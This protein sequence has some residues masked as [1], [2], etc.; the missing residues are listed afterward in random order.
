[1][2]KQ[3][4]S[5]IAFII[6]VAIMLST[7]VFAGAVENDDLN[8]E[9]VGTS[10]AWSR[11]IEFDKYWDEETKEYKYRYVVVPEKNTFCDPGAEPYF[12]L[13]DDPDEENDG[14]LHFYN[15]KPASAWA[16][17]W[18]I[19]PTPTGETNKNSDAESGQVLPTGS[20][21]KMTY[22]VR[23][24]STGGGSPSLV[25]FYGYHQGRHSITDNESKTPN[26]VLK[27]GLTASDDWQT[28]TVY[29]TTPDE[30]SVLTKGVAN[31][32]YTGLLC[33]GKKMD[34]DL[35]YIK[36]EKVVPITYDANG[37]TFSDG[38][39]TKTLNEVVGAKF[40]VDSPIYP[41]KGFYGWSLD[42]DGGEVLSKVESAHSGNTLY[43]VWGAPGPHPAD[44]NYDSWS[45]TVEFDQYV[46]VEE[47]NTA[48]ADPDYFRVDDDPNEEGDKYLHYY[49]HS[50]AGSWAANWSITP[51]PTGVTNTNSDAESGQVLPTG[52]TFKMTYRVRIN[53]TGGGSPS[54]VI[55]YGYHQ[56]RHSITDNE[57]KTP[58]EVLKTGL[59]ASDDWQT[60]TVYF[61]TPDEYSVLTKG[62]ANRFYTGLLCGGY[63]MDYDLDYI[64]LEKVTK[65]NLYVKAGSEYVLKETF[66]GAPGET[67]NLPPY[68]SE[69]SYSLYGPTGSASK[70]VYG[71]WYSDEACTAAPILKFGNFDVDLYCSSVTEIPAVN[72]KNQD[73]FVGFD[74]YTQRT[75]GLKNAVVTN[76]AY[77]TG[78]VSLK[79]N[80]SASAP[81]FFELKNDHTLDV[82]S[83]KTYRIDF[84]YKADKNSY[85]DFGLANGFID[86]GIT[87]K[88]SVDLK[89][90]DDWTSASAIIT[91]DGA[92]D[93]SVLAA[94]ISSTVDADVFIDTIIVS[95]ATESVGVEAETTENGEALR[96]MLSYGGETV[97]MA[98]NDYTVTE[99]GVLVKGEEL[100]TALSLENADKSGIF[101]FS[102]TDLTKN[103]SVN[104]ITGT[105]VYSAYLNGFDKNDD[106]K[107]SVRGYV[108]LTDGTVYYS[109]I[110]TA[111]ITDIPAAKDIVPENANLSDYYVYL[112]EGTTLPADADYTVTTYDD[113]FN[114]NSAVEGNLITEDSYVLFSARP[115]F[116]KID[117]PSELKYL[118]HAGTKAELYYGIEAQI[119]SEKISE[120]GSDTVNYLFIT[121]IHYSD[122]AKKHL[123]NQAALMAKMANENDDIDFIV[124]GGDT[125]TGMFETKE[126]YIA[127][128]HTALDPFL[129]STKPVFV[130][131]GN[132]DD[133]SYHLQASSN[134]NY[135]LYEERII[136]DLDWQ[137]YIID[138]Y[139]NKGNIK[140]VQDD[141]AKRANSKYFYY[142]L[143][144]KKTRVIALDALDYEAKYDENGYVLVDTD[145]DGL[146]DGMPIKDANGTNDGLKYYSGCS[147][148]GY[149]ADQIR[150]LAEDA[151]GDL[152]ADYDVI[153][154]SHMG[155]DKTTNAY[156]SKIWFG[157]NIREIIKTF[158]AGGTYTAAL[159]DNWG[160][161]VSVNADFS[162]TN[163][164][165]VVWQFGHQHVE[166]TF[167]ESDVGL[168]QLCTPSAKVYNS[169]TDTYEELANSKI[170]RKDLPWRVYTR[171]LGD[172]TEACF[173]AMSVSSER[174]Y[175]FS[176]GQGNNEKL[177]YAE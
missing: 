81:A 31:R 27:T 175:R 115:D 96:F 105:T 25:I 154:V 143:E 43:A 14:Y 130:L 5:A 148:W 48:T 80:V 159:T 171:K 117:V 87:S 75:E 29:F 160:N 63:K 11:T 90:A 2:T 60:I 37:G 108:K 133:N 15:Y 19:T 124:I 100:D 18:S 170:N 172:K 62:V 144:D 23:I 89:A 91:A 134:T 52:S 50:G 58:N 26:E 149:S 94:K 122:K 109:D 142:D 78:S 110:L 116:N 54:L 21:F 85:I 51:T 32:F 98:G 114:A 92:L 16:A 6:S 121:D 139:T 20:T 106:Y 104:P 39:T 74:T 38:S 120:V 65:T 113:T 158:N 10:D 138:R 40:T 156:N 173:N 12:K 163:G 162:D 47:K 145:S 49:N 127:A 88:C 53:S 136:T 101:A 70:T 150:W 59:T 46:V 125:T 8:A 135:E 56:G 123:N 22:R 103:W 174:V 111:S 36:I 131:M 35:D 157:E 42:A 99:H 44:G 177:V 76:E 152:P 55:F 168:W 34:Y 1:M 161:A 129:E 84:S 3:S 165:I 72:T 57:S 107:V 147:Y 45:R 118:V 7:F 4:K 61:T 67:L 28:I 33:A 126:E 176:V 64:K 30:Y 93:N 132:H 153:F 73:I 119:V 169:S 69:E 86:G 82:L 17:N 164:E 166:V 137:N 24:N 9:T 112:P 71:N 167:Y 97:K 155:I 95:S 83:G 13:V 128:T 77:N 140:V 102:Q 66:E 141:P 68:Y 146:L 151:L 41:D 79:A